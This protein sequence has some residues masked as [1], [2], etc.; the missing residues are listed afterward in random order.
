MFL[1]HL[2]FKMYSTIPKQWRSE[3]SNNVTLD[4]INDVLVTL[5]IP[6]IVLISI[7]M[8]VGVIGNVL[9]LCIYTNYKSSTYK[10]FI[11]WLG[12]MDLLACLVGKPALIISMLYPY[13]SPSEA[14]CH[15]TRSLHV[16]VSVSAALI[17][18]AI[19]YE[20]YKKICFMDM[21]Q[22]SNKRVNIICCL[23]AILAC[24]VA[25]PALFV[26]GDADVDTGVYNITGV[27]CFIDQKYEGSSFP[28]MYFMAQLV[29][30]LVC[31]IAMCVFY[32]RI[33]RTLRWHRAFVKEHTYVRKEFNGKNLVRSC[34]IHNNCIIIAQGKLALTPVAALGG[35][36][37]VLARAPNTI[38]QA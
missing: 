21:H 35:W 22:L 19:S 38:W 11:I 14:L 23:A 13:Q 24:L 15:W 36:W 26:F 5:H 37:A 25:I 1:F 16:F 31:F 30:C 9:V 12:W 18:L 28:Q 20:R 7:F 29:L 4:E 2:S 6:T 17:F 32:I 3:F 34:Y 8:F 33:G 10:S 27:E